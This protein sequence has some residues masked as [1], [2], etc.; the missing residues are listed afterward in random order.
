[1]MLFRLKP[2][3]KL[4]PFLSLKPTYSLSMLNDYL[5]QKPVKKQ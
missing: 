4:Q 5:T 2:I 1:M 3:P